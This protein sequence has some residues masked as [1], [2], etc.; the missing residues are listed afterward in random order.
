MMVVM[1]IMID[2]APGCFTFYH[3]YKHTEYQC[4]KTSLFYNHIVLLVDPPL[5]PKE[6]VVGLTMGY[7]FLCVFLFDVILK[8]G[9]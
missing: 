7:S 9:R 5:C 4:M 3:S 6:Q 1:I 2:L 8:E